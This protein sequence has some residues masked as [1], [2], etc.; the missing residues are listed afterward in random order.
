MDF[1]QS[2]GHSPVCQTSV[3]ILCRASMPAEPMAFRISA[4][5]WSGPGAFLILRVATAAMISDRRIEGSGT[6]LFQS[7]WRCGRLFSCGFLYRFAQYCRH[8]SEIEGRTVSQQFEN[9]W[10]FPHVIGAMD[11]KHVALQSPFNSGNDFDNYKLFPSIVLFALV[12]ANYKFLYVNVGTKGRISD[13]GVFKST[14]LY[15]KLEKK[16]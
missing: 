15:K 3:H 8:L 10:N 7:V 13:G 6:K 12:D 11:G 1:V 5:S 14:N 4:V 16:N 9:K 2:L